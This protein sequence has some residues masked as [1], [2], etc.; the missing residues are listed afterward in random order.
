MDLSFVLI[1][2]NISYY[3]VVAEAMQHLYLSQNSIESLRLLQLILFVYLD[4][5]TLAILLVFCRLDRG[6]G[7]RAN[8][9]T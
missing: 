8:G 5:V 9:F 4:C 7:P 1:A 3:V 2:A 6:I